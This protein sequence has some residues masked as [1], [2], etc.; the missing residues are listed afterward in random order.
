MVGLEDRMRSQEDRSRRENI[1]IKGL[2][3]ESSENWSDSEK[4]VVDFGLHFGL[5]EVGHVPRFDR[6]HRLGVFRQG[7]CRHIIARFSF[8]KDKS[9]TLQRAKNLKDTEFSVFEDFS[10]ETRQIRRELI[11]FLTAA[12]SQ[13]KRAQLAVD[14]LKIDG[15]NYDL[16][17]LRSN[18]PLPSMSNPDRPPPPNSTELLGQHPAPRVLHSS[19][20][21]PRPPL[22]KGVPP[23]DTVSN[24]IRSRPAPSPPR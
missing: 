16:M 19:P 15:K 20:N 18:H 9:S 22:V 23:D 11:P 17:S 14:K 24:P 10:Q 12:R 2:A 13:G 8:F 6:V 21:G 3:D 4:L 5:F 7:Q 1:L